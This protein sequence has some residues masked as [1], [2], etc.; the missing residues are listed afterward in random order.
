VVKWLLYAV[1]I[2]IAAAILLATSSGFSSSL[3]LALGAFVL[4]DVF[5]FGLAYYAVRK[6]RSGSPEA[7]VP[8]GLQNAF[9]WIV[10]TLYDLGGSGRSGARG[11]VPGGST[12]TGE[13]E[14]R[15]GGRAR[16]IR[17]W[18]LYAALILVAAAIMLAISSG[19]LAGLGLKALLDPV[20]GQPAMPTINLPPEPVTGTVD[21]LGF[22]TGLTNTLIATFLTDVLLLGLAYLAT[23]KIRAGSPEAWTPGGLQNVFEWVIETLYGLGE[24]VLGPRT[25]RVFWLGATIFLLVLFAN[26]MEMIPGIDAIGWIEK[27]H[28]TNIATYNKGTFLGLDT[29]IGPATPPAASAAEASPST[30]E[31][32]PTHESGSVGESGAGGYVLVPFVRAATTDLNLTLSLALLTMVMVQ[33]YGFRSLGFGYLGKFVAIKRLWQGK[34]MGLL[35]LF[36]GLLESV[37]EVSKI[38]SFAFRL[39]GNIFAG[40]VLLFVM[41]FLI[42]F[43]VFGSMVFWGLEVFV[44]VIQAFVFMMLTFVFIAQATA[45]HGEHAEHA[46]SH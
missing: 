2:L 36:V 33:F 35:D 4:A 17:K 43:L 41:G 31:V 11:A 1:L 28:E 30:H 24:L 14:R 10:E 44:G 8:R 5:L 23:R 7:W 32:Q 29:V 20:I 45:G 46:E 34:L 9:E 39:F 22:K 42:P 18:L 38:I 21:I 6:I 19:F 16:V 25:K 3:G 27:T 12:P 37:S 40:Q 26:W 13:E 15:K